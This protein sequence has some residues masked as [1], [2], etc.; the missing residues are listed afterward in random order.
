MQRILII[1]LSVAWMMTGASKVSADLKTGEMAPD[2][3]MQ[4]TNGR[5]YSLSNDKGKFVVLEWFNHDCPFV[6]KH[7]NSG[8]MQRL[9]KKYTEKGVVWFSI[10][11]SASG[12]QGH[13]SPAE[14]NRLTQE[15][16]ANPTAVFLDPEGTVGRLYGAKTTPHIFIIDPEGLLIYQGAIDDTPSTDVA[17]IPKAVNYVELALEAAMSGKSVE[18]SST[19]SYGCSVKY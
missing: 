4:D 17:D 18:T 7:Y 5:S 15:K 9:Q 12:K 1:F 6:R 11:S 16:K 8:N 10:N 14:A 3:R 19:K 2:F 13:Y